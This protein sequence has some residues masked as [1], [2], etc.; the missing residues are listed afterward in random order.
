M[1]DKSAAE[2][3]RQLGV[4]L[5]EAQHAQFSEEAVAAGLSLSDFARERLI[6]GL[7]LRATRRADRKE[8]ARIIGQLGLLGGN[9]NQLSHQT[10]AAALGDS[11]ML[12][13]RSVLQEILEEVQAIRADL[14]SVLNVSFNVPK[15]SE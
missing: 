3:N 2:L 4:R 8:L 7:P 1:K 13:G 11:V 12:S 9:L 5:T 10:K 6:A 14:S 15:S